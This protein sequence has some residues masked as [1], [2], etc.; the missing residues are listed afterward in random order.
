MAG[1]TEGMGGNWKTMSQFLD[2]ALKY[3]LLGWKV[4]PLAP[5]KKTP[6]T[7]HGVKDATSVESVIREWWAKWPDANI[8]VA[9]GYKSGV[10]V[11][12]VDVDKDKGINGIESLVSEFD[13]LPA[14]I[15]QSTPRGG[16]HVFYKTTNPPPNRNSFRSGI[17]IRGDGYYVVLAPSIH[18]N[19]GR[20]DWKCGCAPWEIVPAE[21]PDCLRPKSEQN[22]VSFE[23]TPI[24]T[25]PTLGTLQVDVL[26]RATLYVH[27]CDPAVQGLGGHDKLLWAAQCLVTGFCLTD[28]QAFSI[29]ASDYNPSCSPPWNLSNPSEYKDFYRKITEARKNPPREK[30]TG[31]LLEDRVLAQCDMEAVKANVEELLAKMPGARKIDC[32]GLTEQEREDEA[33][34]LAERDFLTRPTGFLGEICSWINE[35]SLRYQPFLALGCSLAF[36]GA[37]FG[38]KIKDTM[39]SR[40]NL[41]CMGIGGSSSGKGH[42]PYQIHRLCE[43]S[44]CLDLLG[45]FNITGDS[46]IEERLSNNPATLF[47]WDEIGHLLADFKTGQNKSLVVP[48]LMS[49]WSSAGRTF[50]GR[51][52]SDSDKQRKIVQPCC[53]IW[54][55]ATPDRFLHGITPEELRDGWL[56]RVLAFQ[57]DT[58]P[59]KNADF[60]EQPVPEHLI[61]K[62]HEWMGLGKKVLNGSDL[63]GFAT[64]SFTEAPPPQIVV[65]I[66]NDA[67]SV[68]M[69]LDKESDSCGEKSPEMSY[70]WA[71]A[72][73]QAHRIALIVAASECAE[74]ISIDIS[75]A[76]YACRLVRFVITD[77]AD[78]ILP[79]VAGSELERCKRKIFSVIKSLGIRGCSK[80]ELT[81]STQWTGDVGR[82]GMLKDLIEA[83]EVMTKLDGKT[84]RFWTPEEYAKMHRGL[85]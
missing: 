84:I 30:S 57:T 51:E 78:T 85:E 79:E 22:V 70:L 65:P 37:L 40:T 44:N 60:Q 63:S 19:G 77:F 55:S 2:Y 68:F 56:G 81:R 13:P 62:C 41:Y 34:R 54:G 28:S 31:W 52:Y 49:M 69:L 45:G 50:L 67:K 72:E 5:G 46:A 66:T 42:A 29:L 23:R 74:N 39:G 10:Y 36:L 38:R 71:K 1:I 75:I 73:E 82:T 4:F 59:A 15:Q 14:T 24:Y 47:L 80:G 48:F 12:D 53:C 26:T 33:K 61:E 58:K 16:F 76:D 21:Y 43:E 11:V 8:A 27:E 64:A 17:D 18:P 20:Y 6:I 25:V 32:A 83:G 9:C 7:A 3:A 35:T